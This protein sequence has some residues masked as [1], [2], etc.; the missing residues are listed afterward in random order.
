MPSLT[1]TSSVTPLAAS[2]TFPSQSMLIP[3]SNL[4]PGSAS[5]G[6]VKMTLEPDSTVGV[7]VAASHRWRSALQNQ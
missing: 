2:T 6:A 7:P 3:Y 5:I 4:V 1:A